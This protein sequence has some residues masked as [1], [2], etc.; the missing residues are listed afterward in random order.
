MKHRQ[1]LVLSLFAGL[2]ALAINRDGAYAAVDRAIDSLRAGTDSEIHLRAPDEVEAFSFV[3]YGDRTGGPDSGL[4]ILADAVEMTSHLDPEF[5]MTVGDLVNGY[6]EERDWLRQMREYKEVMNELDAPWFPLPGNHDVYS[7]PEKPGGHIGLYKKHFGPLYY[8]FDYRWAHFVCLFTDEA[9]SF[10]DPARNQNQNFS[11]EQFEWLA[12]DL[13]Q[14]NKEQVFVFQH[15]PRWNYPGTDWSRVHELLKEDGR[16]TSVFAGHTHLYRDDGEVD[17]IHYFTMG[18]TG[19]S[20]NSYDTSASLHHINQVHVRR[21]RVTM[22]MLPVG[23]IFGG[24]AV[25]GTELNEMGRLRRGGWLKSETSAVMHTG[26]EGEVNLDL[27]LSNPI[28]RPVRWWLEDAGSVA[29]Q[30][31]EAQRGQ[32]EPGESE[33]LS[34]VG[35]LPRYTEG[36][37]DV[38]F[39][40]MVEYQLESN[41]KQTMTRG[42][43]VPVRLPEFSDLGA[44]HHANRV[45]QLDG[46]SALRVDLPHP[47]EALTL[48]CWVRGDKTDQRSGLMTKT[49]NSAFGVF[50]SSS[51]SPLPSALIH[52]RSLPPSGNPGYTSVGARDDWDFGEW[53]HIALSWDGALLR[54]F[55]NGKLQGET[56][57]PG[58]VTWNDH[59]LYIGADPDRNGRAGSFF[60]GAIDEVRLSSK[61]RY[62][63]DF[64]P[65]REPFEADGDTELLLHLDTSH[66]DL[67]PDSSGNANHAWAVGKPLFVAR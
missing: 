14:T 15:H 65:Q 46:S 19:A 55:V 43:T 9:L 49:E 24:D 59:P 37:P 2:L 22:A 11:D 50:W 35:T 29:A 23:S 36:R 10:H 40:V 30:L 64:E 52:M 44:S 57:A 28:D 47:M 41:L 34:L 20:G 31:L 18:R 56:D 16:P 8:S 7:R 5:V 1:A 13:A 62:M 61:A 66:K 4:A 32:L 26:A 17:G 58:A 63:Q 45:L 60:I 6:N 67:H 12:E 39:N 33:S 25:T 38:R 27:R 42:V 53:M 3:V 51:S 48:E 21:D 54:F